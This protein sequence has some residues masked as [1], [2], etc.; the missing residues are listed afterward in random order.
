M[1]EK[2]TKDIAVK[3]STLFEQEAVTRILQQFGTAGEFITRTRIWEDGADFGYSKGYHD[4]EEHYLNII[5]SQHKLVD[6]SK[7]EE[8]KKCMKCTD[9][10]YQYTFENGV[11]KLI[12]LLFENRNFFF[13]DYEGKVSPITYCEVKD[14]RIIFKE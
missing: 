7:K 4:A 6:E 14:G 13:E 8:F 9:S 3:K 11:E 2:E 10:T 12:E 5:D 1:S